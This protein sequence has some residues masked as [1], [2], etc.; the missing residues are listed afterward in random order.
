VILLISTSQEAGI[1]DVCYHVHSILE[2]ILIGSIIL[3]S[4]V[5]IKYV[6][7][8]HLSLLFFKIIVLGEDTL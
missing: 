2:T 1:M 5:H 4:C 6:H 8:I 3:F 7:H